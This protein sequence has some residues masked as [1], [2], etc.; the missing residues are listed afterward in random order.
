M[1]ETE[2]ILVY[3]VLGAAG[4]GRREVLADLVGEVNEESG[5]A[6]VFLEE[7]EREDAADRNLGQVLRWRWTADGTIDAVVPAQVKGPVFFVTHG[8]RNPVD[9]VEAF[10]NW[11]PA[12]NAELGRV[13]CVVNCALAERHPPL[14]AWY[15]A[16]VHFSDVVLLNKREGVANKWMS[17][18]QSRY[19][20]Q[21]YPCLIE[22]VRSGRVRNPA[23]ILE[24]NPLRISHAFEEPVWIVEGE[25]PEEEGGDEGSDDEGD[26]E[27]ELVQV[28]DPYFARRIGGR[29]EKEIPDIAKHLDREKGGPA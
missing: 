17:D 7:G 12:Q 29:R 8:R 28:E 20:D 19:E 3:L 24:P 10:K 4:S 5:N 2:K 13:L 1:S 23:L 16:C 21:C 11:L 15:D 18:F 6:L 14:L 27:V 22:M 25:N 26:E 9:Q